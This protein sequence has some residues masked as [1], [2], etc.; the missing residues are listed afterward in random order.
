M[1]GGRR[2]AVC[3]VAAVLLAAPSAGAAASI[4]VSVLSS[5][6]DQV[7]GGDALL[8]VDAPRGLLGKLSVERNGEDV[9]DAFARDGDA[10][11]GLVDGLDVGENVIAVRPN[12]R[13]SAPAAARA[14]LVNHPITGPIFSGPHQR[15]FV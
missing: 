11:V 14:R 6:A 2:A 5:R 7:S 9:T 10:L 13:S 12:R 4:E 15:P 8:R 3:A 1:R